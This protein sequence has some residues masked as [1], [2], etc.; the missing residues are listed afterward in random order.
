MVDSTTGGLEGLWVQAEASWLLLHFYELKEVERG[1]LWRI[2]GVLKM[3]DGLSGKLIL[4][5]GSSMLGRNVL[6]EK[7]L[8][9]RG[10]WWVTV[11]SP[12]CC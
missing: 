1:Q 2:R 4:H 5:Y 8:L 7:P 3:L 12:F 6:E 10:K 11:S 9:G